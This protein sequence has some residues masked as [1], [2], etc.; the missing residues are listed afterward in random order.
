ML[1]EQSN[2]YR[3]HRSYIINIQ[4]IKQYIKKDGNYILMKNNVSVPIT[5]EKRK[6]FLALIY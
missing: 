2:F 5:R 1:I 6:E 4:H 3:P